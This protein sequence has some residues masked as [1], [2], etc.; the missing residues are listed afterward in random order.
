MSTFRRLEELAAATAEIQA[1][2]SYLDQVEPDELPAELDTERMAIQ[3]QIKL[4]TLAAQPHVWPSIRV[5]FE[6]FRSRYRNEYQIH[7]RDAYKAI[8][9]IQDD[10]AIA[11]RRLRALELLNGVEA[12]GHPLGQDLPARYTRLQNNLQVCDVGVTDVKVETRPVC[13]NC[14]LPLSHQAPVEEARRLRRDLDD[15]L[16]EQLRRLKTEA[17][18]KVLAESGADRM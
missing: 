16:G 5:Q 13:A 3:G 8:Q 17:I 6:R 9:Q 14:G 15:A 1:V 4:E 7:H 18:R 2:K 11:P 12:L 10:L